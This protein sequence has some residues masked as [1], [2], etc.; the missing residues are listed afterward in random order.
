ME[1]HRSVSTS[2]G[3]DAALCAVAS[4]LSE[5]EV[6]NVPPLKYI[7]AYLDFN[8]VDNSL[9]N[10]TAGAAADW[11]ISL[12]RTPRAKCAVTSI[13]VKTPLNALAWAQ[14][15]VSA[16][17]PSAGAAAVLVLGIRQG[18]LLSHSGPRTGHVIGPN[19]P[20]AYANDAAVTADIERELGKLLRRGP[21]DAPPFPFFRANPLG[22]VFKKTSTKPRLIHNLSW[23]RNGD[24]VNKHIDQFEIK[25]TAFDRAVRM[26]TLLG[27]GT[28]MAKLDI[29]AAYRCVPIAPSD[30]PLMGL[31]WRDKFYFDIVM[32]FGTASATAIFEWFSSAVEFLANK[33]L[34]IR[35][36]VHY[37][38]DFMLLAKTEAQCAQQLDALLK[39]CTLLGLP[40]SPSKV[41][42][43]RQVM[44]LLGVLFDS[45]TMTISL[46][47]DRVLAIQQQL[48]SW[49]GRTTA[50]RS[51]L[52]SLIGTLSF[53]SKVVPMSR[54]FLRRMI[55]QL[56]TIPTKLPSNMQRLLGIQF[57]KD[58]AWWEQF[59]SVRNGKALQSNCGS[60]S[61]T[62]IFTDA[63]VPGYGASC[64]LNW[65]SQ[66][67]TKDEE[68]TARAALK[69]DS[70]PWKECYAIAKALATF[71]PPATGQRI[72]VHTDCMPV[73]N[74]WIKNDTKKPAIAQLLRTIMFICA[75]HDVELRVQF[76]A[77]TK[78]VLADS[79]SRGEVSLFTT[80]LPAHALSPTT[81]LPLPTQTW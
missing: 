15:L 51:E 5:S 62:H 72:V 34:L 45:I 23:P 60:R 24:S 18:V 65:F 6:L 44:L 70:M 43:A 13:E 28:Y 46:D 53:A 69:R 67:W 50:S 78:N 22:I 49:S 38:D 37:I 12:A 56:K 58:V 64:N 73:V 33:Q 55:E 21:F 41:E 79:L 19:L 26:L 47:Q 3:G 40:V 36:V 32:Q 30:W 10:S 4:R 7:L 52:Q 8:G 54:V 57:F 59:I 20:S 9:C 42:T 29:E 39:L 1:V 14:C 27:R 68:E 66:T 81:C 80:Y 17:Y 63:C 2:S 77:G 25:L 74:A 11:L 76:I 31:K 16:N 71:A 61:I 35:N 48:R 75:S